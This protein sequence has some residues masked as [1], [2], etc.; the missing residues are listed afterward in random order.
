M[1]ALMSPK[2]LAVPAKQGHPGFGVHHAQGRQRDRR[3]E[4]AGHHGAALPQ[5]GLGG[6]T[7]LYAVPVVCVQWPTAALFQ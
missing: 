6:E 3:E 4:V 5:K 2:P 1:D 7:T